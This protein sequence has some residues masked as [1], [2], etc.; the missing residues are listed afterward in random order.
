[1]F[2]HREVQYNAISIKEDLRNREENILQKIS[3]TL[4][5]ASEWELDPVVIRKQAWPSLLK[6]NKDLWTK[7]KISELGQVDNNSEDEP[8]CPAV[9]GRISIVVST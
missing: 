2:C 9:H 7:C 5:M 8:L 6:G 4:Y 1:M 3:M